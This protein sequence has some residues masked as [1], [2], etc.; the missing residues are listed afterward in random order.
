M[1]INRPQAKVVEKLLFN[2]DGALVRAFFAV[3]EWEGQYYVKLLRTE[4]VGNTDFTTPTTCCL[5]SPFTETAIIAPKKLL[6]DHIISP[7]K[8]FNFLTIQFTRA[9]SH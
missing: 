5:P 6:G 7:F 9:P 1:L 4:E 3:L 2:K 8:D